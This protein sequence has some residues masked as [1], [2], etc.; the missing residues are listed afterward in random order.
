M[1]NNKNIWALVPDGTGIKNYLYSKAFKDERIQLTLFHN[2]DEDTID[3]IKKQVDVHQ[4]IEIPFYKES[5]KEKFLRELIHRCRLWHNAGLTS[6][7]TIKTFWK[8]N[9]KSFKLKLF[10]R[11][12]TWMAST[13]KS[14]KKILKLE[15]SYQKSLRRNPFYRN[16]RKVLEDHRPE[17]V[18]CT[19][20]RAIKAPGVFA[21]AK[22]L[23]IPTMTVIYSWDNLPKARLALESNHYLVW[24][25]H[26]KKELM[27]FYP[28]ISE[29]KIKITGTPQ[30][31]FYDDPSNIIPKET[32]YSSY[33]LNP[34]KKLICFSGD[35][36][37]T[38]PYDPHYLDDLASAMKEEG[39]DGSYTIV[40]RRCPV[41]IS[42]R[43]DWV[44]E[45]HKGLIVEMPPLWNF[46]S[47][48]WTA[49]Y[50]TYEDVKLLASVAHYCDV[51][52]NV[53]STMAFDFG[54]F[55][56]PCVYI[57]YDHVIDPKWSVDMIY[58]YPH[59]QS[60]PDKNVVYW[61]NAKQEIASVLH[62]ALQS[63]QTNINQWF[64]IVSDADKV[65]SEEIRKLLT[66]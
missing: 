8:T 42:G 59:F 40:F 34:I 53:G 9:H 45:K 39:L 20:Q 6:N 46:N 17:V 31:E 32:F 1:V 19:H 27:S 24:S 58:R 35:D 49:V 30:F 55:G 60:M 4:T 23:G 22:D 14:Y 66:R 5:I 56:K 16:V 64:H 52:V 13:V 28:E 65:A 48:I 43:Y 44:I 26:M 15:K 12:V 50:P 36:E 54:M 21:A 10:Y 62:K 41:D 33:G 7:E 47:R 18:F 29:E 3:Q 61:F 57:N 2:F 51:V 11:A 38:S 25:E 37:L 63:G